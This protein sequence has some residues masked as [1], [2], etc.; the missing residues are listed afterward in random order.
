[1]RRPRRPGGAGGSGGLRVLLC[2]LLLSGRPGGCSAISAHGCLFD[3]RLCSHLE[4]CIQDGLFGQC[5][6]GVG[7]AR[8]LLQVTSPI[9]Q[10][11]Q[12]VL[13]QLMSQGLS[14]HDDLT[15]YVIS[16][17]MERIPRLRPPELHPRDRSGSVPRRPGP[18]GELL[19]QGIPTG[20]APAA[21]P[22][23]PRPA[24]GGDGAGAGSPLNPL[25][26]ELLPPLLEH[27]LLP[28]Q[29][30]HPALSYE[31]A[32]LQPYLFHQFG[33]R[34]GSQGSESS[35]GMVS[36]G[37]LPKAEP[38]ALFS[39]TAPKGMFGVHPGHSYGD[40][41]GPSPAQLFQE[42]GLL[43]LAQELPVPSRAR[44]PRLPEHGGS[45][46]AE[47]ASEGYEEEGLE[48]RGEKPP[49]PAEQP[50]VTLQ[51]LAA[52]LAGYGVELR[53]LT[54]EQLSTLST[55]LQLLPKGAGR[56][57]GGVV[58]IGA[59]IKKTME[60]QVQGGDIVEPPPA[61]PS[62][63]GYPTASPPSG[64]AQQV[65]SPESFEFPKAAA[66]PATPVLLEKKSPLGQS[67]L[68]ATGQ[69]KD[70]P[71][72]EEYGYIVT[73][74]KPLS[75]AAGVKLLEILAEHVHMSSG[76]FIN[77]SVVGPAL[78][79][80]IRH[81]EQNLSL[82]DVTQ[83][84][85][86]V[87][88]ELETQTGLQILQTG[89]GQREEAA[90]VL[91]RPARS[92]S[93]MRSVLLTLVALA[94]VAGLLVALA[95]AL[96]VRQHARQR[97]KERL[98]ALGPEGAHGD[99]TFEYQF[100]DAAQ[101]S[102]SSHSST[103]SWCEEPA[104]ANMDISTGHM[105]LAYMEDHL[106][107]QDRLAKEWQALCAYQAEP[108]TCATAQG[109]SNIKKNR[110]PD[111]LPYDHARIKLKVESSPSRS[112]YINASPIIEHDPRMPAYIA[113]QG[114]LSHTI[115]DFWQMVWE[116]GCTVIVM[117]TPL[118]EDGV[119]Q[120]DRYWPDEGSSLYHIYEVNL[121][122]EHIWCEDF[123][124]RSFYL[125]NVQTQETRTL[126]QFHF[127]SWPAE[128]TPAS[129][130][131]LLDFRRKVNKCYRGR[132]CPIIV[133]C[134]DGA[135]RTGTYILI[136]MVLNRMAKGVKEIDI[137][138]TLEHVR[139]QRPGLVRSKDQFE[140]AL[141]AVAEEVNAILKALPQ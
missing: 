15:Q 96:C 140:F 30:P 101:A 61:T 115:S 134:S 60:E 95:V 2:L 98:A 85:E 46:R 6:V 88:S 103:P 65:L 22:R 128:G 104:Q 109:E 99:T 70:R 93:P 16:Q 39:R 27:L 50:D 138:A 114:P 107:N 55:L 12:G 136:D 36:V 84:A 90:A 68:T 112:D 31:P 122:S 3:R 72:A 41:P 62:P 33:S 24:T 121:V 106:R 42:S 123:L 92:T 82:A 4:V 66:L 86:L 23:L 14:W 35:P 58:N 141:T 20:S 116:S 119:K 56:N 25:Q 74:Q 129:T 67:Q 94:G 108:N 40:P 26:A 7:Q 125:K 78:T 117:L 133:H 126:T 64:K 8:P 32:L 9:L 53:Q 5:Q 91:P 34:D 69:P 80:R 47:D 87:K 75:L 11:L 51:R 57:M 19:L 28:P 37:P 120:C 1:M 113:T 132:S 79:F 124:V 10:R 97:D 130:R 131:P 102:P 100:S 38:P 83:Q 13:R 77:I 139:D 135:G 137:A 73:D 21:Q 18:A 49:S 111:F 48:G 43:Y 105:I 44:V 59:D 63:H 81:N 89:V 76:S 110:H 118:V 29:P 71:S 52:V 17:E 54:P 45:S 127:L